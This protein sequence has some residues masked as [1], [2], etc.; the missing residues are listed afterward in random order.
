MNDERLKLK[1]S[2]EQKTKSFAAKASTIKKQNNDFFFNLR[3]SIRS[4]I[5]KAQL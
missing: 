1:L 4:F 3:R 2:D 5:S